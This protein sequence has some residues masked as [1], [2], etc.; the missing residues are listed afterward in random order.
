MLLLKCAREYGIACRERAAA[1]DAVAIAS[2]ACAAASDRARAAR[3]A[4]DA[5]AQGVVTIES[6]EAGS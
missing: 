3:A 1:E 2:V 6:S 4:F 5:A